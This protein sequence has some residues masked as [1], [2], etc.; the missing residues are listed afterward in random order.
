MGFVWVVEGVGELEADFVEG[1]GEEL[2]G[3]ES[4]VFGHVY[5]KMRINIMHLKLANSVIMEGFRTAIEF[6]WVGGAKEK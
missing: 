3:S 2:E 5:L 6:G 1:G 4:F